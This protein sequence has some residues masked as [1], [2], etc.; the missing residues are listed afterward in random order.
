MKKVN[1]KN[2]SSKKK[3]RFK[4]V[5][6]LFLVVVVYF[7]Y[8]LTLKYLIKNNIDIT[9]EKYVSFFVNEAY[10]KENK[11]SFIVNESLRLVSGIDLKNPYT[12]LDSKMKT[13]NEDVSPKK[14]VKMPQQEKIIMIYLFMK[15]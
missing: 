8:A 6:F 12:I 15:K 5:K 11:Y 7:T 1:L 2:N 10:K 3:F 13:D 4:I 9:D 14:I